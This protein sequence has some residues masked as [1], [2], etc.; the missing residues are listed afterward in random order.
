MEYGL[1]G[2]TEVKD[3]S[4]PA[5]LTPESAAFLAAYTSPFSNPRDMPCPP[6]V[7]DPRFTRPT[8]TK[9]L[10]AH[11]EVPIDIGAPAMGVTTSNFVVSTSADPFAP[12]PIHF[13]S[14][15]ATGE[16]PANTMTPMSWG[17]QYAEAGLEKLVYQIEELAQEASEYRIVGHGLKVWCNTMDVNE[18]GSLEAGQF[19][20]ADTE[21]FN[22]YNTR[23]TSMNPSFRWGNNPGV[24]GNAKWHG[25]ALTSSSATC[26]RKCIDN[27]KTEEIGF[28]TA[29]EGATVRWTDKNNFA[30]QKVKQRSA[31]YPGADKYPQQGNQM[32]TNPFITGNGEFV[33][34]GSYAAHPE[35]WGAKFMPPGNFMQDYHQAFNYDL[36]CIQKVGYNGAITPGMPSSWDQRDVQNFIDITGAHQTSYNV[37][38]YNKSQ[39]KIDPN[40]PIGFDGGDLDMATYYQDEDKN[41]N[42]GLYVQGSKLEASS[43]ITV[44]VVWHVEYVPK[45]TESFECNDSPVD[46]A[47]DE[48][49]AIAKNR[50]AF[51]IVVKGHSFWSNLKKALAKGLSIAHRI[52][53]SSEGLLTAAAAA[54]PEAAPLMAA[55]RS[56][57]ELAAPLY[58]RLRPY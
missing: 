30:M 55:A 17:I 16:I 31:L 29:R 35:L 47:F 33:S 9:H 5:G 27:A 23:T 25:T 2:P 48:I 20:Y 42:T 43:T 52:V 10:W 21:F 14:T 53:G 41:F 3:I 26:M 40:P 4:V 46:R 45:G 7:P 56:T 51:P 19:N 13:T 37:Y 6:K 24:N 8:M 34:Q 32:Y 22:P 15:D 12:L 50:L 36:A 11:F 28:L 38:Y 44:Q 39:L 58:K 1:S 49:A 54:F 18:Q 57:Y